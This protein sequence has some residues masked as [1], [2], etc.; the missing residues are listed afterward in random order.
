MSDNGALTAPTIGNIDTNDDLLEI[1]FITIK[2]GLVM[3]KIPNTNINDANI[4]W[5]TGRGNFDRNGKCNVEYNGISPYPDATLPFV[6]AQPTTYPTAQ[7]TNNPTVQLTTNSPT[8]VTDPMSYEP[9][10][11]PSDVHNTSNAMNKRLTFGCIYLYI[12]IIMTFYFV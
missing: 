12:I 6:T 8:T 5:G 1:T 3:Y 7:L 4:I 11:H 10:Q 9:S 2:G